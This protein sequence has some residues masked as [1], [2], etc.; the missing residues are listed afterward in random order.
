[1]LLVSSSNAKIAFVPFRGCY[2]NGTNR[3][4]PVDPLGNVGNPPDAGCI[5]LPNETLDLTNDSSALTTSI[6]TRQGGGGFPGT[7][8]CLGMHEGRNRL[9]GSESRAIARKVMVLL[10]DGDQTYSDHAGGGTPNLGSPTPTPY[11]AQPY[12]TGRGDN[13]HD[14]VPPPS[15]SCMPASSPGGS[16]E[17]GPQYDPAINSLDVL[18]N[19]KASTLKQADPSGVNIEI[20]VLRF[21]NSTI[22]DLTTGTPPG[23]CDPSLVGAL[24][25]GDT[26]ADSND[27]RD[28]NLSRCLASNTAMGDPGAGNPNDHYFFAATVDDINRQF[29]AIASDIVR[30]RQ[31][32]S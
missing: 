13:G 27:I 17:F 29:A 12:Q 19:S 14:T 21:A 2:F 1:M 23:S 16:Q 3:N 10:T 20:Y 18:A 5:E 7:N 24:L 8:V 28:R 11:P 22:D 9:F 31:L 4:L 6:N 26:R 32:V 30:K 15:G 25:S